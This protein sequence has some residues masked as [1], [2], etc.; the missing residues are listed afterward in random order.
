M[1]AL[2][3]NQ[4]NWKFTYACYT[5][6]TRSLWQSGF[7]LF[8]W[9]FSLETSK[10]CKIK[11]WK[12]K[13]SKY[14][15]DEICINFRSLKSRIW[16]NWSI[17]SHWTYHSIVSR[18][19]KI[20]RHWKNLKMLILYTTKFKKS[21]DLK[22]WSREHHYYSF[23]ISNH[24]RRYLLPI[25]LPKFKFEETTTYWN[26]SLFQLT[27]LEYLELGDN[28]IKKIENLSKNFKIKRLFLGANQ[29]VDIENLDMLKYIE[30]LSLPANAIQEIK[31]T[32][33]F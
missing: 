2:E 25:N 6:R 17:W 11:Q 29:I 5:H 33:K 24:W 7:K 10:Y 13:T 14:H 8:Y 22:R 15:I 21:K 4:K 30:V 3:F 18:C 32:V 23:L 26:N 12:R 27:E 9:S 20:C 16:M 19:W 31:V 28:R 1:F